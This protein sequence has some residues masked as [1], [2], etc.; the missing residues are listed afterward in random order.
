MV[1]TLEFPL[2]GVQDQSL[3]GKLKSHLPCAVS[4]KKKIPLNLTFMISMLHL[5]LPLLTVTFYL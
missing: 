5:F 4:L 1:K 3:V 2:R